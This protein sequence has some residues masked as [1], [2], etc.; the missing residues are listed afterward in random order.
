M[1]LTSD[2]MTAGEAAVIAACLSPQRAG[3]YLAAVAHHD[4]SERTVAALA[5]YRWNVEVSAAFMVPIHLCEVVI[6]NAAAEA[7]VMLYGAHWVWDSGFT[8]TLPDPAAPSYSPRR[9]LIKV[10]Q[11]HHT[12]GKVIPELKLVFWENLFTKRHDNRLW[13]PYLR[14]VLPNLDP[15]QPVKVL[16]NMVRSEIETVRHLRNR[17]AHHEPIF[18]R[19]LQDELESAQR[20]VHWKSD[21]AVSWLGDMETV[22]DL[23][24]RKPE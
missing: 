20:L 7:L 1:P 15:N 5:L 11:R 16:R 8:Q 12:V 19:S 13:K 4:E 23:L 21:E 9:D 24:N 22:T 3:T 14:K 18:A 17:V 10:R 2:A 6:R